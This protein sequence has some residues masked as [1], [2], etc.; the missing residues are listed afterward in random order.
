MSKIEILK[1]AT[2]FIILFITLLVGYYLGGK[3]I[4]KQFDLSYFELDEELL[5]KVDI[6]IKDN[7]IDYYFAKSD[8]E[9]KKWLKE[10][11]PL[12]YDA[13][14]EKLK[15]NPFFNETR[16]NSP[17]RLVSES[18]VEIAED[19]RKLSV[20]SNRGVSGT[21]K[22]I[23]KIYDNE[24]KILNSKL[25]ARDESCNSKEGYP[26]I[27]KKE[28]KYRNYLTN[29][30]YQKISLQIVPLIKKLKKELK[31]YLKNKE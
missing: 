23:L 29:E 25:G 2:P 15:E 13:Y 16:M 4:K 31:K 19:F 7:I 22:K 26:Q 27:T 5:K 6:I 24:I 8:K 20:K 14:C 10:Y 1:L 11:N 12:S 30:T 9:I 28:G 21:I 18:I 3:K 17:L